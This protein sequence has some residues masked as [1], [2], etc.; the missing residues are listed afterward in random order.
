MMN[1]SFSV[2]FEQLIEEKTFASSIFATETDKAD[3]KI[4]VADDTQPIFINFDL[5]GRPDSNKLDGMGGFVIGHLPI[6]ASLG[7]F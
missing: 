4:T 3:W 6:V 7:K 5:P 1:Y 2:L